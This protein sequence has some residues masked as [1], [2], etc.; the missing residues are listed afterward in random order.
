[1]Q[2]HFRN[3]SAGAVY[4]CTVVWNST[5]S[6]FFLTALLLSTCTCASGTVHF[7]NANIAPP[8]WSINS[9]D[10]QFNMS[11]IV[12]V[13]LNGVSSNNTANI[14]G[15]FAGTE[16]RGVC[17]PVLIGGQSY[18]FMTVYSN[19]FTGENLNFRLY[20]AQDDA[21]YLSTYSAV[22]LSNQITGSI[23]SP[24]WIDFS[25]SA[26]LPPSFLPVP[27]DS[28]IESIPFSPVN[29]SDYLAS[30]DGDSVSYTVQSSPHLAASI[31][32]GLMTVT[33][34][35]GWTGTEALIVTATEQTPGQLSATATA[36]FTV[37]PYYA[38]PVLS[39]IPSQTIEKGLGQQFVNFDLDSFLIFSGSCREYDYDVTPFSGVVQNPGWASVPPGNQFMSVIAR[40]LFDDV[41]PGGAGSELAAFV[42]GVLVGKASPSGVGNNTVYELFLANLQPGTIT[43]RFYDQTRQYL[44]E[45]KTSL[46]FTPGGFAG[47]SFAPFQIQVCPLVLQ[48]A[49]DGMVQAGVSDTSWY[50]TLPVNFRVRD[51]PFPFRNSISTANFSV[52]TDFDPDI[53]SPG[54]VTFTENSCFQLYDT[55][56]SDFPNSEGN[57]LAYSL[58]GGDDA[59]KFIINPTSGVLGWNNFSPDFESPGDA[60]ADNRYDVKIRVLNQSGFSDTLALAVQ[61]TNDANEPFSPL[62]NGGITSVCLNGSTILS[63]S[64]GNDYNW[65]NGSQFATVSVS[66][67]GTYT[68]TITNT[69]GCTAS[70][71]ALVRSSPTVTVT[72]NSGAVCQGE[73]VTLGSTPSFGSS[74][75]S[76]IWSGPNGFISSQEDPVPFLGTPAYSGT[77]RV[78]ATDNNGCTAT[79]QTVINVSA[80]TAP[81]VTV[82]GTSSVCEGGSISLSSVVNGGGMPFNYNWTGPQLYQSSVKDP[83][84]DNV[85]LNASGL[86]L[87]TVTDINGCS[88]TGSVTVLVRVRPSIVAFVNSPVCQGMSVQAGV[89]VSGTDIP[90]NYQWSGPSGFMS[91]SQIPNSFPAAAIHEGVYAV[92]VTGNNGCSSVSTTYL[93]VS[94]FSAPVVS[95]SANTSVCQGTNITLSA[96]HTGGTAPFSYIWNGPA[97]FVSTSSTPAPFVATLPYPE[98]YRITVTDSKGCSAT[99]SRMIQVNPRPA[100]TAMVNGPLCVGEFARLSAG[101]TG[102]IPSYSFSWSGPSGYTAQGAIPAD[103]QTAGNLGG[104]YSVTVTDSRACTNTATVSLNITTLPAVTI[105]TGPTCTGGVLDLKAAVTGGTLPF[106]SFSWTGPGGFISSLDDPLPIAL[107][108]ASAGTYRVTVTDKMGCKGSAAAVVSENPLPKIS[109][110]NGIL[111]GTY[112]EGSMVSIGSDVTGGSSPYSFIWKGPAGYA[113]MVEDPASFTASANTPG[114]YSVTVTDSKGCTASTSASVAVSL[115]PVVKAQTN[116][117]LCLNAQAEVKVIITGGISPFTYQWTG[118]AGFISELQQN[119][120]TATSANSGYYRVTVTDNLGCTGT[121]SVTLG[122][123]SSNGPTLTITPG[124]SISVCENEILTLSANAA[125]GSGSYNYE[126]SGPGGFSGTGGTITYDSI[127]KASGGIYVVT[128]TDGGGCTSSKSVQVFVDGPT[129]TLGKT[130]VSCSGSDDGT[131]TVL[132]G[133]NNL[134]SYTYSWSNSGTAATVTSLSPGLYTVTLTPSGSGTCTGVKSIEILQS[135]S[136]SVQITD[137]TA[138]CQGD[139]GSAAANVTGG[140]GSYTY[141]WSDPGLQKSKIVTNLAPGT[142]YVTVTDGLSCSQTASVTI[143]S[144]TGVQI[145]SIPDIGPICPGSLVSATPLSSTPFDNNVVFSWKNGASAGLGNGSVS[146][147]APVI[148]AFAAGNMAGVFTVTAYAKLNN[149]VSSTD[150]DVVIEDNIA[151]VL[152]SCPASITI[153]NSPGYCYGIYGWQLPTATDNCGL[154]TVKQTNGP[155]S[156]GSFSVGSPHVVTYLATDNAGNNATC[157]FTVN[158]IDLEKPLMNCPQTTQTLGT[159]NGNCTHSLT[160]T[161]FNALTTDNCGIK[162]D[163]SGLVFIANGAFNGSGNSLG[164]VQLPLGVTNIL[165]KATDLSNNISTCSLIITVIDDDLPVISACPADITVNTGSNGPGDCTGAVPSLIAGV[166]AQDNCTSAADLIITQLPVAGTAFGGHHGDQI[167]VVL[168]VSDTANNS[169]F[170]STIVTLSDDE[171]PVFVN[172]PD[173]IVLYNDVDI[174]GANVFFSMPGATDNCTGHV[175]ISQISGA[176]P[177]TFLPVGQVLTA[178]FKAEDAV[179]NSSIC[180][181]SV[182]VLDSQKPFLN[183]PG[184]IQTLDSDSLCGYRAGTELDAQGSDNCSVVYSIVNNYNNTGTLNNAF[185]AVGN[186]TVTWTAT[187]AAGN[188]QTCSYI[189]KVSDRE[190]PVIMNCPQSRSISTSV[191]GT[192]D[193]TGVVPAMVSELVATDNCTASNFLA[194]TQSPT[195]GTVFGAQHNDTRI[196]TFTVSD[197]WGNT[198]SCYS[199]LTLSDTEP[200]AFQNCPLTVQS[201]R[202]DGGLCGAALNIVHPIANDNCSSAVAVQQTSGPLPGSFMAAGPAQVVGFRATDNAGNTATC[203]FLVRISDEERPVIVTCPPS[204]NVLTSSNGTGDCTGMVPDMTAALQATDNCTVSSN[205]SVTQMPLPGTS[206]G[207]QHNDTRLVTFTATDESG[208]TQ[209]CQ[210]TLTLKDDEEP[211][212]QTCPTG[213]LVFGT[214]PDQ[215]STLV[216]WATPAAQDNCGVV[217]VA[218]SSGPAP[219]SVIQAECP[220]SPITVTYVTSDN[221]GNGGVVCSFQIRVDDVQKPSFKANVL[222]P[223]D[224]TVECDA[225]PEPYVYHNNVLGLLVT[226]DAQD[227]CT[228]TSDL[229]VGYDQLSTQNP[230]PFI[231]EYYRYMLTRTWNVTDCTGNTLSHV[232]VINVRDTQ[233]PAAVCK[234]I[235]ISLND[236]GTVSIVPRDLDG[237]S[238]D[239]CAANAVLTF[240]AS[241]LTFDCASVGDNVVTLTVTDPCGNSSTCTA[242]VTVLEGNVKC[243]PQYDINGSDP[244]SCLNNAATLH[245]GQFDEFIQVHAV[246]GQLWRVKS[247]IDLYRENSPA[248]PAAPLAITVGTLLTNGNADGVDNDGDGVTDEADEVVYYSLRGRHIEGIGFSVVM[249]NA[250]SRQVSLTNKCYY[251]T[252]Y[253]TNLDDPFCLGTPVFQIGVGEYNNAD[254]NVINVMVNGSNTT[255]FNSDAL[256]LGTYTIMATFD[257]GDPQ[258]YRTLNGV[259]IDGAEA[260]AINDPG[261][262][263]KITQVVHVI[264]TPSTL[265]C[266]DLVHVSMDA[267]C[268]ATVTADDVLEGTYYCYDDFVVEVDRTLPYGNGP[269]QQATFGASDI[270]KTYQYRVTHITTGVNKCWGSIR[271]EDKLVPA[272]TCPADI[273]LACSESTDILNT[274]NVAIHDC[275]ATITQEKDAVTDNGE[276][277]NPRRIITRTFIVTDAWGNQSA[278]TQTITVIAFNLA[279]VIMPADITVNCES[280]YNNAGSISPSNTGEPSINWAS[281]SQGTVCSASISFTD[282]R[283]DICVGSYEIYRTWQIG[284]TCLPLGTGNPRIHT[285]RVRVKDFG[286]PQ[287]AC[288]GNVTVSVDPLSCCVTAALP[289]VI[290]SEGCSDITRLEANITGIDFN[291]SNTVTFAVQGTLADFAGNNY[292]NPDTLAVFPLAQCLPNNSTYTVTYTAIDGCDNISSCT[293]QLTVADL[294]QPVAACDQFTQ[295]ALT[296]DGFALVNA[297]TFD[298]GSYDNCASTLTYKVRRMDQNACDDNSQYDDQVKFC[299]SDL[300][301]TITVIFRVYDITLGNGTVEIDTFEGHYNDCMVQVLVEDKIKPSCSA[302]AN[303]TVTCEQFDPSLWLYGYAQGHDNCCLDTVTTTTSYAQFDTVC[304]KGTITRTFRAFD[305]AG[306]STQCTQRVVITYTQDYF[307]RFPDDRIITVCDGTGDYGEPTFHGEDCELLGVTYEDEIFTVVP[308]ACFKIERNWKVINWCTFDP[309]AT[310]INVP[311]P[312]P[313]AITNHPTNLPGPIVSPIQTAGDPWKSTIVKINPNDAAATNYSVY[314]DANANFY[315]YKQIIKII[316]TQDPVAECS[317]A[318]AAADTICDITANDAALWNEMYWWD[319]ANSTHDLGDAPSDISLTATDACSGANISFEYQLLLD[320]DGDGTMETVV[321]S[322]QLG[323]QPGGLGWNNILYNNVNV[324]GGISRQF[325]NRAV[326]PNQKWGF[327]IQEVVSGNKKTASVKFNTQQAQNTYVTPQLPYGNHKIKWFVTDG[328]GNETICEYP[329]EIRDCK[330]PTVVCFNGLSVNIMPTGMITMNDVDFLEYTVDNYTQTQFLQT[331]IRKCGTGSGFP[332]DANGNP[333]TT[334]TFNC[335]EVGT[336]CVELWSI[337]LAG[338]ADYCETYVIVQDNNGNCPNSDKVN[339]SGALKTEAVDGVEEAEVTIDGTVNFAPPFSYFDLSDDLGEYKVTNSV[340]VASNYT[341]IP[342][343]NDSPLNGVTTYDLVLISK[344]ILGIEPLGS[345]YKMIAADANKSNSITTFDIVELRKLILGIY[346]DL[347]NNTSW[348][349]VDKTQVF[350]NPMNP[351]AGAIKENISIADAQ[352]NSVSDFVGIKIGDVNGTAV[353]NSAMQV[354]DRTNGTLLFDVDNRI[355][356]AGETFDVTFKASE[357]VQGY[358]MT[359]NLNGL[360]VAG[361]VK[362]DKVSENNF[363]VFDDAL[364]VSVDGENSFTVTFRAS[365]SGKLSEMMS[366]SSRI[367]KAE[368]YNMANNRLDVALRFDGQTIAGVGFE[369]YQNQPNPFINKTFIGFHLPET[370]TATLTVY[371][372]T[373]RV[374]FTQQGDYA[375]GYNAVTLDRALLSTTGVLYYTLTAGD[376]TASRK[377]IQTRQ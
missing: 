13:R 118:P 354:D 263:Q 199:Y 167:Q 27:R 141:S 327:A 127:G 323:S 103:F 309:N 377:M 255:T 288:P 251:P 233:R 3:I 254:G 75:Y 213:T 98:A 163:T 15:V 44:Y 322:T 315:T 72:G 152:S 181:S 285:Q 231:C 6:T 140:S 313:N 115:R 116:G 347:P 195:A 262:E 214:D 228:A 311:N 14:L 73:F 124:T 68:V 293:F 281:I 376:D 218:Q 349:F 320:L 278:C 95:V 36:E 161:S 364:T 363:G 121:S 258:P 157:S 325:D 344:H 32:N 156:G 236:F 348:R 301:D 208:N 335:S 260:D 76:F 12:R 268:N 261:C 291:S 331:G 372:E 134:Y 158:V 266:N 361:I 209:S 296:A 45:K 145:D 299:C 120:F 113:A 342:T 187:D 191:N 227:N 162:S 223:G 355:V 65:S 244:C 173:T 125:G 142:Y 26:D 30:I 136:L 24:A 274:G 280:A 29:L 60:N 39:Q 194:V 166:V 357:A 319:L 176:V 2:K 82:G 238:T 126:W 50:G 128:V 97:G 11:M 99:A 93:D 130:D 135:A 276:C 249:E 49:S 219:G 122:I 247:I 272:L 243:I 329:I 172:C 368:G 143:T 58:A 22:F 351:F 273:T 340:P 148:P 184:G 46:Q 4:T 137:I 149:C 16:L 193:C 150:F 316:D 226:A 289:D 366:V 352:N 314:Y 9:S 338:N 159:N 178:T 47:S 222:M 117:P 80:S 286:G 321:N 197:G 69:L 318:A 85:S 221:N 133:S 326:A 224:I 359:L 78:T 123:S 88:S 257:A 18:F 37:V 77:Y 87:V 35:S 332:V 52:I 42:N 252:P 292:W 360:E 248:P 287:F 1:M 282:V 91:N 271:I 298:D 64:G 345:P 188:R 114:S 112:C 234:N 108:N 105:N 232:Q 265:I 333:I 38:P 160:G 21:V 300:G 153:T 171:A 89:T 20:Y 175:V 139:N 312:N 264:E 104:I 374:V 168:T 240:T 239:N 74:P 192:G 10:F 61:L 362:S 375:K 41:V 210:T 147:T 23:S 55:Q 154:S 164:N 297:E 250:D 267:D 100:V 169:T 54:F 337:D 7:N 129:F 230:D 40:P 353:A 62:I 92:T 242:T 83:T 308:D 102:G 371:D 284:N 373:G 81:T 198:K 66:T 343:K 17:T 269:W 341:V 305:C 204:R 306:N 111:N 86:Y 174:C 365:K 303:V 48:I 200:P 235:T 180:E 67:P 367:T 294:I 106:S 270:G 119:N 356:K 201:F 275:S 295:V 59:G 151:P 196:I 324:V 328:C 370:A 212:F 19:S 56:T 216:T 279:D 70:V 146:G 245:D 170:C 310:G 229:I 155:A 90:Y 334:V 57:G 336:Q 339:V 138:A 43:F 165:W 277:G 63:A 33:P 51:C 369:L 5:R 237:G 28:T 132:L 283:Q 346:N 183:C 84:L 217:S 31:N 190:S 110:S 189:V 256:G 53:I 205:I 185:F 144:G 215:C 8:G 253:F 186:T 350:A 246:G 177:G 79:S 241:Q 182:K 179:G 203:T 25:Q 34:A 259:E 317:A 302:P 211:S 94:S 358:Q 220:P 207:A 330:A 225:V 206:F 307:V 107:T 131:A 304:N 202:N 96:A 101:A 71:T 109:A 290:V